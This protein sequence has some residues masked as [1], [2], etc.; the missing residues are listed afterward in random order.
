MNRNGRPKDPNSIASLGKDQI[1][2][3][4]PLKKRFKDLADARNKT[5]VEFL[6]DLVDQAEKQP[7]QMKANYYQGFPEYGLPVSQNP[8]YW[9]R[10][11]QNFGNWLGVNVMEKFRFNGN[12]LEALEKHQADLAWLIT[13]E[14]ADAKLAEN[15]EWLRL[16][17]EKAQADQ[18]RLNLEKGEAPA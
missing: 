2:L 1:H 3:D 12:T 7:V 4:R 14:Y 8:H 6:R 10:V 17:I 9:I 11:Y 13:P 18:L 5:Q 16:N 15:T